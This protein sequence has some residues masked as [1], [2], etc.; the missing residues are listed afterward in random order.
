MAIQTISLWEL[1]EFHGKAWLENYPL[2]YEDHRAT[3]NQSIL[4]SY[5]N[6][7][8]GHESTSLFFMAF[9]NHMR[10]NMPVFNK[11]Y[12]SER[13]EFDP[14]IT[15]KLET[16][17]DGESA[18]KVLSQGTSES[19]QTVAGTSEMN[20]EGTTKGLTVGYSFPQTR[21]DQRKDYAT[22]AGDSEGESD[23]ATTGSESSTTASEGKDSRNTESEN[24]DKAK[25]VTVGYQGVPADLINAFRST[26]INVDQMVIDSLEPLFLGVWGTNSPKLERRYF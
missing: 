21:I 14:M 17:T 13:I 9:R 19:D 15:T 24:T 1:V 18:S 22:Q 4:D 2:E 12:K 11:L 3:L 10:L 6:R 7:E 23:T 5:W 20:V 16:L 26:I 25:S 8:I